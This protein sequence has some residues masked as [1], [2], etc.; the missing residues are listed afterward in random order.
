M[1]LTSHKIQ[2]VPDTPSEKQNPYTDRDARD[3]L[4]ILD[5]V[6][7]TGA[8]LEACAQVLRSAGFR[9]VAALALARTPAPPGS[10]R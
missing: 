8:T 9:E 7:T 2:N 4:E 3:M 6:V 5:D 1:L 10:F